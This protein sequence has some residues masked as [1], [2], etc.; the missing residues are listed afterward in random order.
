MRLHI[1]APT[2]TFADSCAAISFL[3]DSQSLRT[4]HRSHG[5]FNYFRCT[6]AEF[7]YASLD[8]YTLCSHLPAR[9]D[10]NASYSVSVRQVTALLDASFRRSL[11]V[12]PL[13][14][15]T[16]HHRQVVLGLSPPVIE[17]A[18]HTTVIHGSANRVYHWVLAGHQVDFRE[19]A[20]RKTRKSRAPLTVTWWHMNE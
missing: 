18:W 19:E 5:K 1:R 12:P 3:T 4:Q 11:T 8:G 7:T 9:V 2:M 14:F 6:P 13:R 17:H 10:A 15:A 20:M 16:L